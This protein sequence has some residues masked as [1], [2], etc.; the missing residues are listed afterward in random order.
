[1]PVIIA[2]IALLVAHEHC[3]FAHLHELIHL[4]T[5]K[6]FLQDW[7]SEAELGETFDNYDADHSGD[8]SFDEFEKMVRL[9]S[10][11]CTIICT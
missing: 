5:R 6:T 8:I 2:L 1:M 10:G 7:L 11:L 9:Q 4:L 3:T